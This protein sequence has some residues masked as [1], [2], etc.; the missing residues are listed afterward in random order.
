MI[1]CSWWSPHWLATGFDLESWDFLFSSS[2]C[3]L[4]HMEKMLAGGAGGAPRGRSHTPCTDTCVSHHHL[5]SARLV[6]LPFQVE[7]VEPPEGAAPGERVTF[8]GFPGEA[9][10]QLN[11]KKK[12]FETVSE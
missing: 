12:I 3:A 7:L 5:T 4:V 10:E 6:T 11:P 8:E 1:R 9:D 2:F